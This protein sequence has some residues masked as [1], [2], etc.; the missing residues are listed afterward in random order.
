[1]RRI[2]SSFRQDIGAGRAFRKVDES[3]GKDVANVMVA[4]DNLA[5]L[6]RLQVILIGIAVRLAITVQAWLM[7]N[8]FFRRGTAMS[9]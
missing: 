5:S 7:I 8:A 4:V 9:P 1:M 2:R 3:T 6:C